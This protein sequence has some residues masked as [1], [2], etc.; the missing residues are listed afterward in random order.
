MVKSP[1]EEVLEAQAPIGSYESTEFEVDE[2]EILQV[3]AEEQA[4]EAEEQASESAPDL[5]TQEQSREEMFRE[6]TPEAVRD[7]SR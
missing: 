1:P 7:Q 5:G 6:R 4:V 3:E 2:E